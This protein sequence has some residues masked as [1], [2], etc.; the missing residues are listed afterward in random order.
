MSETSPATAPDECLGEVL[1]AY[2]EA[3]DAGWAPDRGLLLQRYPGLR[4]ELEGFFADQDRAEALTASVR[5]DRAAPDTTTG[6]EA[7]PGDVPPSGVPFAFGD[8]ELLE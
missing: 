3:V 8:Y 5:L 6:A 1:A 7:A 2:L 4:P